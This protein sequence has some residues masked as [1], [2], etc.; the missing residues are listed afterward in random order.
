MAGKIYIVIETQNGGP[1]KAR[2][3]VFDAGGSTARFEHFAR[4]ATLWQAE[5]AAMMVHQ[6]WAGR[7]RYD[8]I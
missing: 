3:E 7:R 2:D 1:I 6:H 8:R 5:F 4:T